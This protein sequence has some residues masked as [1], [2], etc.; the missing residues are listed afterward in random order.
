MDACGD[1]RSALLRS[2]LVPLS[3]ATGRFLS[4]SFCLAFVVPEFS[5][6]ALVVFFS[7]SRALVLTDVGCLLGSRSHVAL[8][9]SDGAKVLT[10]AERNMVVFQNRG[11]PI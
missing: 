6:R 3:R 1:R 8:N 9:A 7:S 5:A 2:R 11:T 4:T 10:R